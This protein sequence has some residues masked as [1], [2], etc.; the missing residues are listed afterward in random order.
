MM[1]GYKSA[2]EGRT[3]KFSQEAVRGYKPKVASGEW[4]P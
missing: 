2:E 3:I 1:L 4:K